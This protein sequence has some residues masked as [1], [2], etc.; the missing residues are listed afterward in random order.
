MTTTDTLVDDI[1][2]GLPALDAPD[3]DAAARALL[4]FQSRLRT[5]AEVK[6]MPRPSYLLDGLIVENTLGLMWGPWGSCKTF[7]ALAWAG[8]VGSGSWWLG[9][10]VTK[11]KVLYVA[12]RRRRG[13]GATHRG[14]R[15]G[16]AHL[17]H[18]R[19]HTP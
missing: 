11:T 5:P 16:A 6:A 13:T 15:A 12:C 7:L 17:P 3:E 14:L 9:R 1:I 18:A 8:F 10:P 2:R 19:R 4:S